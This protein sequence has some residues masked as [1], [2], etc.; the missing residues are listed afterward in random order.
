LIT[1]N[2]FQ[3]NRIAVRIAADQ[4]HG[5]RPLPASGD[6]GLPAPAPRNHTLRGNHFSLNVQ[7]FDL[8][9]DIGTIVED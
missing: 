3:V 8:H 4:D 7:D 6:Y 2:T 1:N 9:G 5:L